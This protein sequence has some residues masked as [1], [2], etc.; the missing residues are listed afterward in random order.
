MDFARPQSPQV[1]ETVLDLTALDF[2]TPQYPISNNGNVLDLADLDFVA[3][4]LDMTDL[5]FVDP[6]STFFPHFYS[7]E[8]NVPLAQNQD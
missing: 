4:L 3:P 5:E 8:Q 2:V 1:E 6:Q 7:F